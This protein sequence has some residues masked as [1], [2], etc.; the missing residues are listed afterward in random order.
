M[1][2]TISVGVFLPTLC[3]RGLR[4]MHFQPCSYP[5]GQSCHLADDNFEGNCTTVC[6]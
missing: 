4:T 3:R 2:T 1:K 5:R 6:Y